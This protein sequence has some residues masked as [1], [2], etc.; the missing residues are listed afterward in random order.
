MWCFFVFFLFFS[1]SNVCR[2]KKSMN[3]SNLTCGMYIEVW[4]CLPYESLT[5]WDFPFFIS[6]FITSILLQFRRNHFFRL[7]FVW[8]N[9][10]INLLCC[11]CCCS[12]CIEAKC[13]TTNIAKIEDMSSKIK[14]LL[15]LQVD[16]YKKILFHGKFCYIID[17]QFC[18]ILFDSSNFILI[19][20][21]MLYE[22]IVL[23]LINLY[24]HYFS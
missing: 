20:N 14:L 1:G 4:E 16:F 5:G 9:K 11:C 2:S 13:T 17:H 8:K 24:R 21:L 22:N 19:K 6:V 18:A 7:V 12:C 3:Y 23:D 15:Q 10:K